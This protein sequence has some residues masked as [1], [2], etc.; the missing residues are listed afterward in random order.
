MSGGADMSPA[1]DPLPEIV[2][3]AQACSDAL[4]RRERATLEGML[5][6]QFTYTTA[7]GETLDREGY[8]Q[9]FVGAANVHW[10][11]QRLDDFAV[12]PI[13]SL[14]AL[15]CRVHNVAW[16]DGTRLDACFSSTFLYARTDSGWQCM[17]GRT[18]HCRAIGAPPDGKAP[19]R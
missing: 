10:I 17:A 7:S 4:V 19:T 16:V 5:S 11:K 9:R 1:G 13:G 8:L 15:T 18:G 14:Y 2:R 6:A 12:K 3:F